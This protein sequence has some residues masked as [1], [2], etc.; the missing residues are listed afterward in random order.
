MPMDRFTI[1]ATGDGGRVVVAVA[2]DLDLA[3][4]DRLWGELDARITP[5]AAVTVDCGGLAFIDSMGL[6]TLIR[7]HQR[8]EEVGAEFGLS[9]VPEA[10]TRVLDLA[11][12]SGLFAAGG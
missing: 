4:A 9:A 3:S 2:G 1:E 10:V 12:V 5:G 8:A 7:A 6:R 11:G